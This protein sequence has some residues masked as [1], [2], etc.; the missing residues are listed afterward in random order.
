[1]KILVLGSGVVGVTTAYYLAKDGHE[2]SVVDR[3]DEAALETSYANAGLVA[4]GH[5]HAWASPKAPKILW[6]SL[7]RA[8]QALRLKIKPSFRQWTW[9]WLFLQQCTDERARIN[10]LRKLRLCTYS[11]ERLGDVVADTGVAYDGLAKGNVY[12][13]RSQQTFDAGAA[14]TQI[15]QDHGLAMQV[16]DRD[17]LARI[18]PA[19]EPVKDKI[20]GG[21]Y[22]PTD[23]SGDARMFSQNLAAHCAERLGVRFHYRTRIDRLDAGGGR[24][25]RVITD[26]GD[27]EADAYVLALG[28]ASPFLSEG[29]GIRLPIYPVKGYSVTIP[30]G[31]GNLSPR[32]GGVDEDNLVA[33]CPMGQR[34]RITSTAE[35]AGYDTTHTPTDFRGDVQSGEGTVSVCRRLPSAGVLGWLAAD[36]THHGAPIPRAGRPI[37]EPVSQY[38]PRTHRLDH[39][40]RVP[41]QDH[42][43][44]RLIAGRD[45]E[46]D[47]EGMCYPNG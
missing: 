12:L 24:V 30:A 47:T 9:F 17:G 33:I 28:Y 14:R 10:T 45:P 41:R 5:A 44:L 19:L 3:H 6:R 25:R 16:L 22:S 18:E 40:M 37:R 8:D 39:V 29:I 1:M 27:L 32:I 35:F 43:R 36:D 11:V 2:V 21:M 42:C 23:Q 15:L 13:Y 7:F 34:L 46:I 31:G 4:P 26:G 20:A 38:R